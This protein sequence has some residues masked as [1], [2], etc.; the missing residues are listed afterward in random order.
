M[1]AKEF[2]YCQT[3]IIFNTHYTLQLQK[4]VGARDQRADYFRESC[5][6]TIGND[7]GGE[8]HVYFP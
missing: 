2:K 1:E 7:N 6:N 4:G 8:W 3:Y 5:N